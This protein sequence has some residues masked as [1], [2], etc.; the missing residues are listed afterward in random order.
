MLKAFLALAGAAIVHCQNWNWG[1]A[2]PT[3]TSARQTQFS[4]GPQGLP[5]EYPETP[6]Y[7]PQ[8]GYSV[9]GGFYNGYTGSVIG[10]CCCAQGYIDPNKPTTTTTTGAAS[11]GGGYYNIHVNQG[12]NPTAQW[13]QGY[14]SGGWGYNYNSAAANTNINNPPV[15]QNGPACWCGTY[16]GYTMEQQDSS[17]DQCGDRTSGG[18][19]VRVTQETTVNP[20]AI[21]TYVE[22]VYVEK[23][24][25]V[26]YDRADAKLVP[27]PDNFNAGYTP[28][29]PQKPPP[30]YPSQSTPSYSAP[31]YTPS[32]ASYYTQPV[33][34]SG[35]TGYNNY[36]WNS[37]STTNLLAN[38][39]WAGFSASYNTAQP[40]YNTVLPSYNTALPYNSPSTY[41]YPT[42]SSSYATTAYPATSSNLFASPLSSYNG[43]NTGLNTYSTGY[44]G[45]SSTFYG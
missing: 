25:A 16:W 45:V 43:W 35:Y 29:Q 6:P 26:A 5:Q 20:V 9:S 31:S 41:S 3:P 38:T 1:A 28:P 44:N 14:Y 22:P 33:V 40:S 11:G 27:P 4:N 24:V 15:Q 36:N 30:V 39:A 34:S 13:N 37:V 7:G 42:T 8:N 12:S 32:Y 18:Y 23:P 19:A 17:V 2:A 21:P 10:S